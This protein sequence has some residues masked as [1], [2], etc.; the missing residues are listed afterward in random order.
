MNELKAA[1]GLLQ[2]HAMSFLDYNGAAKD[3]KRKKLYTTYF[4]FI[5]EEAIFLSVVVVDPSNCK[6]GSVTQR[7]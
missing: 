1:K 7:G 6:A 4:I 2:Y 5:T 3:G